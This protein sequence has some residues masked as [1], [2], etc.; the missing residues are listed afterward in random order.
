MSKRST[1]AVNG[2][3]RCHLLNYLFLIVQLNNCLT[4]KNLRAVMPYWSLPPEFQTIGWS[5]IPKKAIGGDRNNIQ[6]ILLS[7]IGHVSS[8][9]SSLSLGSDMFSHG[10]IVCVTMLL[11]A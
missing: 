11:R 7:A 1:G 5:S 3:F 10:A 2:G 8:H 4:Y 6:P 9:Q